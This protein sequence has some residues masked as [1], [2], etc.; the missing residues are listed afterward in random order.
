MARLRGAALATAIAFALLVGLGVWQLQRLAWKDGILAEISD[1]EASPPVALP[2]NPSPFAKVA[3]AGTL[4]DVGL[5]ALDVRDMP[6]GPVE[7]ADR[8]GILDRPGAPPLL[9]DEGWVPEGTP[10]MPP[11]AA[12]VTGYVHAPNRP[13]PFTPSPDPATH[14]FYA[15]DPASIGAALG[16]P[17]LA[18]YTLVA[19]GAVPPGVVPIPAT[20]LPRPPNNHLSYAVTWFAL[21]AG[22]LAVFA[23]Y[24]RRS[25]NP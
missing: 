4:H 10:A 1:A 13:G 23:T 20:T 9:V 25:R 5:Y 15:L 3:A 16:I 6:R 17:G 18:P 2:A 19:L 22:L 8:L 12:T 7:G 21:A 24:A 14:H 11:R